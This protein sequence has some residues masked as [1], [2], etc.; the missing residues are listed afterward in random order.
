MDV[1]RTISGLQC[2]AERIPLHHYYH[3][4]VSFPQKL[5]SGFFFTP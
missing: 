1:N 5:R 3:R 2:V 4:F